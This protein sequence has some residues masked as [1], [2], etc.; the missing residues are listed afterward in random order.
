MISQHIWAKSHLYHILNDVK[1]VYV[2]RDGINYI[3]IGIWN[4]VYAN[5]TES[6][7]VEISLAEKWGGYD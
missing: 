2:G 1:I 3:L 7:D 6:V 5:I 4:G